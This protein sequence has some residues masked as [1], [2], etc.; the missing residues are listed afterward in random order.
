MNILKLTLHLESP[1][2]RSNAQNLRSE[3]LAFGGDSRTTPRREKP[4]AR[5]PRVQFSF[6]TR[7]EELNEYNSPSLDQIS[8]DNDT[9]E[10][11]LGFTSSNNGPKRFPEWPETESV[12]R[13]HR[14]HQRKGHDSRQS[15]RNMPT[16]AFTVWNTGN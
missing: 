12:I 11:H 14:R 6:N 15:G 5:N 13:Q 2:K 1:G 9:R 3:K 8:A 16:P 7:G 4:A 10:I